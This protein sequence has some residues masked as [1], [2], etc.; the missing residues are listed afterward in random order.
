MRISTAVVV[1][2]AVVASVA[3]ITCDGKQTRARNEV[4]QLKMGKY[5]LKAF[6][7]WSAPHPDKA[8]PDK[9]TDLIQYL[10]NEDGNDAWG[11]PLKMFCGPNL[12][13]GVK[14]FAVTSMGADGKEG[15]EDDLKSWE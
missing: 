13:P 4:T 5:A 6:P 1:V 3:C 9:L 15:T 8:C 7:E 14:V 12:P 11:R 2:V 10:N